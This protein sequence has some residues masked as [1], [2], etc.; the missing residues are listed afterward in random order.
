MGVA[1]KDLALQSVHPKLARLLRQAGDLVD[2]KEAGFLDVGKVQGG[3]N[4]ELFRYVYMYNICIIHIC[5]HI[6]ILIFPYISIY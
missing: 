3:E 4:S 6:C 5:L 2:T 1:S